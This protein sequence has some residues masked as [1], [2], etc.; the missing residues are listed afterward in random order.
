M[1]CSS[2]GP[3]TAIAL[4]VFLGIGFLGQTV[5]AAGQLIKN[6]VKLF[7]R[8]A[9][10]EGSSVLVPYHT[11]RALQRRGQSY[12]DG[13]ELELNLPALGEPVHLLYGEDIYKIPMGKV[14]MVAN[15]TFTPPAHRSI[16]VLEGFVHGSDET[17]QNAILSNV[18]CND[19]Q[20][21]IDLSMISGSQVK[22]ESFIKWARKIIDEGELVVI[23]SDFMRGCGTNERKAFIVNE[24][25]ISDNV[26]SLKVTHLEW[27]EV[28]ARISVEFGKVKHDELRRRSLHPARAAD[29]IAQ[30]ATKTTSA[31]ATKTSDSDG[32]E[33]EVVVPVKFGFGNKTQVFPTDFGTIDIGLGFELPDFIKDGLDKLKDTVQ[34]PPLVVNCLNCGI[35]G[36]FK[37]HG[38][39][40]M[41]L[42][43]EKKLDAGFIELTATKDFVAFVQLE[44]VASGSFIYNFEK[45]L[46]GITGSPKGLKMTAFG[47]PFLLSINVVFDYSVGVSV[48]LQTPEITATAGAELRVPKGGTLRWDIADKTKSTAKGWDAT[49]KKLPISVTDLK[50]SNEFVLGLN[51]TSTP[52]VMLALEVANGIGGTAGGKLG[53]FLPRIYAKATRLVNVTENCALAGPTDYS[54]FPVALALEQG[55]HFAIIGELFATVGIPELNLS[56]STSVE[57]VLWEKTIPDNKLCMLFGN[58]KSGLGIFRPVE[59]ALDEKVLN[60]DKVK[61]AWEKT[62]KIP[63]GVDL[64]QLKAAENQLPDEMKKEL[65]VEQEE[66]KKNGPAGNNASLKNISSSAWTLALIAFLPGIF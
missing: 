66:R 26:T 65:V 55:R 53:M 54:S 37:I 33:T 46:L 57:Q 36:E 29:P 21:G 6:D 17:P 18:E 15:L 40:D 31:I 5:S 25:L 63:E 44:V 56:A 42:V 43:P 41:D 20:D 34:L 58:S 64:E 12:V 45:S 22:Q 3:S 30:V 11:T 27:E 39:F 38:K 13:S 14:P 61:A 32:V 49:I 35:E 9:L 4:A 52:S 8:D 28:A 7:P 16:L 62:K 10:P 2:T 48:E 47:I 50:N 51:F 1:R 24:M 60:V 19:A 23:T 59:L